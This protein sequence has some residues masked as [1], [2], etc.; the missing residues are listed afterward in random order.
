MLSLVMTYPEVQLLPEF[1]L[2]GRRGLVSAYRL[3][4]RTPLASAAAWLF[5]LFRAIELGN[6]EYAS[7]VG[8]PIGSGGPTGAASLAATEVP[9]LSLKCPVLDC[10]MFGCLLAS[11]GPAIPASTLDA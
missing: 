11:P 5:I 8:L 1:S 10:P 9:T 3:T 7:A 6:R 2:P 4:G